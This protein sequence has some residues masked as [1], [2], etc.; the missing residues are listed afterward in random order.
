MR[1]GVRFR[2]R[3]FPGCSD[4]KESACSVRDP[5][6]IPGSGRSPGEGSGY[7][8]QYSW[9]ENSVD[10]G[11]RATVRGVVKSQAGLSDQQ[12]FRITQRKVTCDLMVSCASRGWTRVGGRERCCGGSRTHDSVFGCISGLRQREGRVRGAR[13]DLCS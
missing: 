1:W 3:A 7:S 5:G 11:W 12:P 8:L 9:L 2:S 13:C 10:R 4:C 6:S